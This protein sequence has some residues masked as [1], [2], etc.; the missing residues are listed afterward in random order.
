M[1]PPVSASPAGWREGFRVKTF[2]IDVSICN[3]CY[4]CQIA[5]KDEHCSNDWRP[6]AAPQPETGQFWCK[7]NE[8]IRGAVPK[9]K[10]HYVPVLCQHCD[11]ASCMGACSVEGA[12]YKREDGL[13]EIDPAKCNGCRECIEACEYGSIYYNEELSLAQKCT[14]CAHLLDR[15]WK[16]PRCVDACPTGALRFGEEAELDL[17]GYAELRPELATAPRVH[18]KNIPKNFVAGTVYDPMRKEIIEGATVVLTSLHG[19]ELTAATNGWGD[20]W[21]E[22]LDAGHYSLE[23]TA[24]GCQAK[25]ISDINAQ[26]SV[27]LGDLPLPRDLQER[28]L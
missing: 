12:I 20:F 3:G 6:Y 8:Y 10:M 28:G 13:V 7:M 4:N 27:S 23:I 26:E 19:E 21:F 14:G 2:L 9:V 1:P 16:E 24:P 22:G 15:G 25:V 18:Y 5:C 17:T 11:D